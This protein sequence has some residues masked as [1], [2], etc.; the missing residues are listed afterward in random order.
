MHTSHKLTHAWF[1]EI[2][3]VHGIARYLR[4]HV[5]VYVCVFVHA[6]VCVCVCACVCWCVSVCVCVCVCVCGPVAVHL[7]VVDL[8]THRVLVTWWLVAVLM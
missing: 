7:Q 8:E 1:L 5:S 4:M 3:F 2:A 6:C